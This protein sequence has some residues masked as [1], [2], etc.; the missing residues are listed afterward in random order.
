MTA[1]VIP[2]FVFKMFSQ[3]IL[4]INTIIIDKLCEKYNIDKDEA[5]KYLEKELKID[6]K[7]INEDIEEIKVVK[8]HKKKIENKNQN[9]VNTVEVTPQQ[10][11]NEL[12]TDTDNTPSSFCL[13]RV[14]IANNLVVK[15]CSRSKLQG[16]HFCKSHQRLFE[17]GNL[18]YGT[19]ND[20]K[21][22]SIST[23]VLNMK[24][25]RTIY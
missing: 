17:E 6:F 20:P 13:A 7:L 15:Q 12:S 1:I 10:K 25:K 2:D 23:E 14:F 16:Q 18:K 24:V 19:I 9:N 4:E 22:D 3:K 11:E 21:P 8:K 5:H